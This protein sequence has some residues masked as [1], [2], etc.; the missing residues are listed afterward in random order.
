MPSISNTNVNH[1]LIAEAWEVIDSLMSRTG[2]PFTIEQFRVLRF[3][4]AFLA[5]LSGTVTEEEWKS[6]LKIAKDAVRV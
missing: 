3:Y 2:R 5:A 4:N 6:A 1:P